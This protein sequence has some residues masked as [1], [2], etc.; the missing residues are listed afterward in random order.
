MMMALRVALT[1]LGLL[2]GFMGLEFLTDP[3]GAGGDFG[4]TATGPQGLATIRG[5]LTAFFW[6]LGGSLT[7]G[8]WRSNASLLYVGAALA[9]IVLAARGISSGIDGTYDQWFV[10]MVVE[11]VT[12]VLAVV[13][14]PPPLYVLLR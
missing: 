5:D 8:A 14:V 13:L 9:G 7:I 3:V 2:Y 12:V 11:A 4:L 1:G 10:P 6:V